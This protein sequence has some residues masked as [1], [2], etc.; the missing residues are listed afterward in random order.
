[1]IASP[2]PSSSRLAPPFG[3][4]LWV[5]GIWVGSDSCALP[6][7]VQIYDH[8]KTII[9]QWRAIGTS[10]WNCVLIAK[11]LLMSRC[12]YLLDGNGIPLPSSALSAPA[13]SVLSVAA[14]PPCLTIAS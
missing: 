8:I 7:W 9:H 11:S 6:R 12:Y 5:L 14:T 3:S 4:P 10:V 2:A 1:M 13:S